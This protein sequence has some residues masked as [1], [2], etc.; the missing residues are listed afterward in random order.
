[1]TKQSKKSLQDIFR[2][3]IFALIA[4]IVAFVMWNEFKSIGVREASG[5]VLLERGMTTTATVTNI[6]PVRRGWRISADYDVDGTTYTYRLTM[7]S[8]S[9]MEQYSVGQ[10]IDLL[11]DPAYPSLS[12]QTASVQEDL[13]QDNKTV[14]TYVLIFS[15]VIVLIYFTFKFKAFLKNKPVR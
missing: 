14:S 8:H 4:V 7:L 10:Q 6:S 13:I 15:S 1:M 9:K 2:I 3:G 11:Y 5:L 12:E